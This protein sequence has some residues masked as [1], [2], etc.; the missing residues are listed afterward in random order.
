MGN[1]EQVERVL[2]GKMVMLRLEVVIEM[3]GVHHQRW[4]FWRWI[5]IQALRVSRTQK[6]T[7]TAVRFRTR[8]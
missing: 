2:G 8:R 5:L 7:Q 6:K 3:V 1:R 4:I